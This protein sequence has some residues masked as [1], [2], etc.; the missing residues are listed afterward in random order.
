MK[1]TL[2]SLDS[3]CS[4]RIVLG[5]LNVPNELRIYPATP[6]YPVVF[7]PSTTLPVSAELP[8]QVTW[9]AHDLPNGMELVIE[10]KSGSP[11]VFTWD[12]TPQVLTGMHPEFSSGP[13]IVPTGSVRQTRA[14]VY[15]LTLREA[16]GGAT[17]VE[18]DPVVIIEPDPR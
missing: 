1:Q 18:L 12:A 15:S 6:G 17:I 11:H 2:T 5:P 8:R 9:T 13:P 14:W 4:I 10:K 7:Y 3:H 16:D